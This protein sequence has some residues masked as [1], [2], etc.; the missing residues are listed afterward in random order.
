MNQWS[1]SNLDFL[2]VQEMVKTYAASDL[3]K[4][5]ITNIVPSASFQEVSERLQETQE[6]ID[7][8]R[9][10]GEI[11]L[12]GI[13]YIRPAL[14][15][16]EVGGMLSEGELWDIH[17][18]LAA[19]RRIKRWIQQVHEELISIPRM[20][21]F[22]ERITSLKELSNAIEQCIDDQGNIKDQASP[23]LKKIRAQICQWKERIQHTLNELIHRPSIQKML[24]EP[25]ITQ[26]HHRYVVP[27]K[28]EYR[29]QF[30]GIIHDQSSSGATLFIEPEIIVLLNN[31]LHEKEDQERKE[32]EKILMQLTEAVGQNVSTVRANVEALTQIDI[33]VAKALFAKQQKAVC[34]QLTQKAF[35]KLKQARHP[36]LSMEKVVPNDVFMDETHQGIIIT[37]PN[38]GGKTVTLKTIG[39]LALM[40]QAGFP[41]P[42]EEE[43]VMPVYSGIFADIGDEQ[44][45]EQ[46][47][48]TFSGHITQIIQILQRMDERS[49]VLFDELGAGTDPTEGA[50]L[51]IAILEYVLDRGATVV[52]TTHY[53]ELKLFAHTHPKTVNASV[54]FDVN[55][56]QPTYHLMIGVPGRSNAF[57]IAERLGLSAKITKKAR[58]HLSHESL[59]LEEMI[60]SMADE[61]HE[62]SK[63]RKE[64]AE[65]YTETEKLFLE[66]QEKIASWDREKQRIKKEA[67]QEAR[68]V[69]SKA[70]KEANQILRELRD[71]AKSQTTQVKEHEW[72]EK[73]RQLD[74]LVP[75]EQEQELITRHQVKP[76]ELQM[77]DEVLVLPYQQSGTIVEKVDDEHFVVQVGQLK[78]RVERGQLKKKNQSKSDHSSPSTVIQ[79]HT[80]PIRPELDVRGKMVEEAI[81][82]ID[83]Y[84]DSALLSGYKRVY[85]IHGKGTGALRSGIQAFL[86]KHP[87]VKSFRL[88]NYGEGGSGVTVI[89]F[90]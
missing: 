5:E 14:R 19:G 20:N 29:G 25:I 74:Q 47:L 80:S 71:W 35:I 87:S 89:E 27:I 30:K 34:P 23:T 33:I 63:L 57:D 50:A 61:K 84:L 18:T 60:T 12:E 36:L 54:E 7:F 79:K 59:R 41:I 56:L 43:S 21:Q 66:L 1:L 3:A 86:R 52:A 4:Q 77:N 44:S 38:T 22:A 8:L 31:Q 26:R 40:T 85:L 53:S 15:R 65:M 55:T 62:A 45:I 32:I 64:A 58:S 46:N 90:D 73:K 72:V 42:V 16:A 17:L 67:R 75:E 51:A 81:P 83:K 68:Q 39:L 70:K 78:M 49:L 88:G 76:Q 48:S 6:G 10:K 69:I 24:Q 13:R 82:E 2:Q 28:Q 9:I 11:S 37:G